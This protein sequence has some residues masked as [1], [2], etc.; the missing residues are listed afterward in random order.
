L[1][2]L[3]TQNILEFNQ[4]NNLAYFAESQRGRKKSFM[5][6]YRRLPLHQKLLEKNWPLYFGKNFLA[7][8]FSLNLRP[9]P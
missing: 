1:Q 7:I 8:N 9:M 6:D 2:N 5:I 4:K 3:I